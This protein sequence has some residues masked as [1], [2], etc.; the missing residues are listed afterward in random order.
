MKNPLF[1]KLLAEM[2][3][4][5]ILRG[6]TP[7]EIPEICDILAN[8][9]IGILEIPLNSPDALTS[10][11]IA[12][13]HCRNNQLVG[14]GTVLS[15]A[16]VHGVYDC[17]GNFIISPDTNPEVICE[18]NRLKMVS[19]P[20]FLTPTEAITAI[21]HGADYLKLFPAV[22]LGANYIREIK[23]V[24]KLPILAVGGINA[25]NLPLFMKNCIGVGIGSSLYKAKKNPNQLAA[26]AAALITAVRQSSAD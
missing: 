6:I 22:T 11:R 13:R 9:G 16:D 20:G 17:G 25:E 18:T 4:I 3:I 12:A 19:I 24:V 14:A 7:T 26:D 21:R 15:P 5:A 10:I 2:P 8:A 23:A 1:A